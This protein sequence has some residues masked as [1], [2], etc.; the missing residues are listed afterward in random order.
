MNE[1]AQSR[2]NITKDNFK[3]NLSGGRGGG[4]GGGGID[5]EEENVA[6]RAKKIIPVLLSDIVSSTEPLPEHLCINNLIPITNY[7]M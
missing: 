6:K 5:K 4:G 2:E 3:D 7:S 1:L